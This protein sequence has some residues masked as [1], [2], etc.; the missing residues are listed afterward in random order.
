MSSIFISSEVSTIIMKSTEVQN[1]RRKYSAAVETNCPVAEQCIPYC[2][3]PRTI[4]THAHRAPLIK[5]YIILLAIY[6][7][8]NIM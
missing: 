8:Y 6:S 3:G 4:I 7:K 1:P 5:I 2:I